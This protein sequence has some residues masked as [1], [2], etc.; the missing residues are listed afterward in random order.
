VVTLTQR[1]AGARAASS[2]ANATTSARGSVSFRVTPRVNTTYVLIFAG[3]PTLSAASG[4]P[5]PIRVAPRITAA[6]AHRTVARGQTARVSGRVTPAPGGRRLALQR[7]RGRRW[8]TIASARTDRTGRY[9]FRIRAHGAG[10]AA[11]RVRLPATATHAAGVSPV[12]RL[13]TT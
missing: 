7:E 6:L 9:H 2:V 8:V 10:R 3:N 11:Y 4:S 5:V 13:R 12:L 1:P